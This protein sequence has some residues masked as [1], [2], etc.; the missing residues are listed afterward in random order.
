MLAEKQVPLMARSGC[1]DVVIAARLGITRRH[2]RRLRH[3]AG[4]P[5]GKGRLVATPD[6]DVLWKTYADLG[7]P[8]RRIAERFGLSRKHVEH[9][10]ENYR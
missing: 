9:A 4:A 2:V 5:H 7:E 6:E 1:P 8:P 3:R 10:L